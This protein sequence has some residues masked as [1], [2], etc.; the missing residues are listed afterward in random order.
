MSNLHHAQRPT[1][2]HA[3]RHIQVV[4][5]TCLD[6]DAEPCSSPHAPRHAI[7]DY[8]RARSRYGYQTGGALDT[9][10]YVAVMARRPRLWKLIKI[11]CSSFAFEFSDFTVLSSTMSV[12]KARLAP[13]LHLRVPFES[14][15][16]GSRW[17]NKGMAL[18]GIH[19]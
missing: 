5:N 11:G 17:S 8:L 19:V 1:L 14:G 6:N 3:C 10:L 7:S 18:E 9:E 2:L 16:Y 13:H 12:L 15:K 4:V